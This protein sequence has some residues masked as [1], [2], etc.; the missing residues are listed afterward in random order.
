MTSVIFKDL[1]I[2]KKT[3]IFDFGILPKKTLNSALRAEFFWLNLKISLNFAQ[4]SLKKL[5]RFA[6]IFP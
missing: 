1:A 6:A 4:N 5:R 2:L 3:P